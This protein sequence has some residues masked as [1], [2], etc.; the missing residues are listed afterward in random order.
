[1]PPAENFG[2]SDGASEMVDAWI[3]VGR[4]FDSLKSVFQSNVFVSGSVVV[5]VYKALLAE[6]EIWLSGGDAQLFVFEASDGSVLEPG[7]TT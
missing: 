4:D 2:E 1:M 7:N 6:T 5:D 3:S